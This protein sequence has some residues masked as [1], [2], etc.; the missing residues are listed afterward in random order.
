MSRSGGRR[1]FLLGLTG[2]LASG[3]STVAGRLAE[4]GCRVV[5]ADELV[6][7]LHRPGEPGARAVHELFGDEALTE[8]GAV[9]HTE[10]SRRVFADPEARKRLEAAVH[11]LVRRRFAEIAEEVAQD[12]GSEDILVLEATLLVE[13]GYAEDFDLV[14]SVEAPE[15]LRLQRAVER[16]L[17]PEAARARLK[18]QGDGEVRRARAD[19]ILFN[20]GTLEELGK[21]VEELVASIR[22]TPRT[23]SPR[24]TLPVAVL[25]SLLTA[26]AF[27]AC[28]PDPQVPSFVLEETTVAEIHR[29]LSA[30]E[31]TCTELVDRYLARITA[32]DQPGGLHA[33]TVT[34]PRA[35]ARATELDAELQRTGTLRPLH[36]VP[37]IVKDNYDTADL[38][39]AAGSLALAGSTPPDD[40]HQ[41]RELREAGVVVMAK[42]NMAEWAFSPYQTVSSLAG[43]TANPYDPERVP[44]GSSGGTAA[45]VAANLAAAGLGTDTGNSIRGPA[46]H[47][48][49]VGIRPTLGLTS[50]DGIVP[51]YLN[52]DVGGPMTRTVE[53]AARILEVIAGPDPADPLTAAS[54]GRVPEEGY[55][56]GLSPDG[57]AG[58]RIGVLRTVSD[59][60]TAD[61]EIRTLFVEALGDLADLGAEVVDG[62]ELP[63][64]L[65]RQEE[66]WC[67]TFRHDLD[68][69]LATREGAP[70]GTLEEIVASGRYAPYIEERLQ[71]SLETPPAAEQ[72][73]PCL[74][75]EEDPRRTGLLTEVLELMAAHHLDALA[76]PSWSN[77]PR[78][79]GDL[80]SPHGNNSPLIAPHTGQPAITVPMGFTE[81]G[82]PAGLQLLGRPWGDGDLLRFAYAYEQA[83]H[84]RR[85]PEGFGPLR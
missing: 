31:L 3:K 57:L 47:T 52:R 64:L 82:L 49:L 67:N 59:A 63:G 23:R 9:D 68:A 48:A 16:G 80:E 28:S 56:A 19:R 42:S 22:S 15:D 60:E 44:A 71:R 6:A 58:A 18:A 43:T 30:G 8:E 12:D 4:L 78:M 39:T 25:L 21:K 79:I 38:E 41:V 77:P 32:Y 73:P 7:E 37:L 54:A 10:V 72:E 26:L 66:L 36:C 75:V 70:Y 29:A 74:G 1:P 69:Y 76:Y 34:N 65:E 51:L 83:T 55:V 33:V 14:V 17:D 61:P 81:A 11:P 2:G 46:S 40:A 84:H 5:D 20:D 35:P 50:R 62:L 45:A 27:A 13:A 24:L 85:P 53:D